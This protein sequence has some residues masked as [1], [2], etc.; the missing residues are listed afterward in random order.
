MANPE[1]GEWIAWLARQTSQHR[2]HISCTHP[3]NTLMWSLREVYQKNEQNAKTG[4]TRAIDMWSVGCVMTALLTGQS[5]F[6]DSQN[7]AMKRNSSEALREAAAQCNLQRLDHGR[8]WEHVSK[9]AKDLVRKLLV[10]D[11]T[12]RFRVEQALK[13]QW[14]TIDVQG[15]DVEERYRRVVAS[16]KRHY[17]NLDFEERLEPWIDFDLKYREPRRLVS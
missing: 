17:N 13:H 15:K 8:Q 14:F 9:T 11:E 4:Y 5:Y 6:D 1:S 7:S 10:R 12:V 2:E 16:W 3:S